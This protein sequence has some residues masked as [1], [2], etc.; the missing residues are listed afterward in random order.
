MAHGGP[1]ASTREGPAG[2]ASDKALQSTLRESNLGLV[3]RTIAASETPLSRADVA[4]ATSMTRSTVSRLVDDLLAAGLVAEVD[5][6]PATGPGRPA[7]PLQVSGGRFA[8]LGLQINATFLAARLIDLTGTV[9]AED[10]V[11]DDLIGSRPGPV[12]ARLA[13]RA[14]RVLEAAPAGVTVVGTGLALPG[15]VSTRTGLLRR[16]PNL[17]WSDLDVV[18]ELPGGA[19]TGSAV[20]VDNEANLAARTVAEASPGRPGVLRDFIYVSGEIGIGGSVVVDGQVVRGRHGWAG[21]I[22]H[23]CVDPDGPRCR[24]GS[25]G[26]LERYAGR[27]ALLS[28]ARMPAASTPADLADRVRVG[29]TTACSVVDAAARSLGIALAG[30][31]NVLD[32]PAIVLGGHLGQIADLLRPRLEQTL[33]ERVLSAHWVIPW[34]VGADIDDPAPGATGAAYLELS[35]VLADPARWV[36]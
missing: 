5:R 22:G 9:I 35:R 1:A 20:H 26:C 14:E 24:C 34:V 17:G 30:V 25:T 3:L 16:A 32:I 15:I 11:A 29:N 10:L 27:T 7:T 18:A 6:V 2:P 23:V 33:R 12:L 21:E 8:A 19:V 28:A 36:P 4:A 31:V 13:T